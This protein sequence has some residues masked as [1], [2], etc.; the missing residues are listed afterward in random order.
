MLVLPVLLA[1]FLDTPRVSPLEQV[2]RNPCI[3]ALFT[4]F[5]FFDIKKNDNKMDKQLAKQLVAASIP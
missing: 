5:C 2:L 4:N 1:L 3:R